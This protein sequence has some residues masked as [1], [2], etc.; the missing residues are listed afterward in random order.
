MSQY[1]LNGLYEFLQQTPEQGLRKMLVDNKP[2]GDVHFNL[3]VKI[4]RGCTAQDFATH[5][6]KSDFPKIKL[7]PAEQKIKEK[8]WTDCF[9][10][11][12][13]RGLLNPADPSKA[14]A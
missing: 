1:D 14:A 3:L 13:A 6:D 7:G 2:M 4:I 9:Q 11:F 8:F 12:K 10:T 5:A